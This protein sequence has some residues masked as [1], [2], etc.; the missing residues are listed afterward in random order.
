MTTDL[1][2]H[3]AT[4]ISD[5]AKRIA[6][7]PGSGTP[8]EC[9][10]LLRD[11]TERMRLKAAEQ[12]ELEAKYRAQNALAIE[13]EKEARR[14]A[15]A[16]YEVKRIAH[17]DAFM[18]K[19]YANCT[20]DSFDLHNADGSTSRGVASKIRKQQENVVSAA[21]E[22]AETVNERIATGQNLI[23]RGPTGTGKDHLAAAVAKYVIR[24]VKAPKDEC[25]LGEGRQLLLHCVGANF[26]GELKA[27]MNSRSARSEHEIVARYAN[28]VMLVLSDPSLPGGAELTEYQRGTLFQLVDTRYRMERP[29]ICTM[30]ATCEADMHKFLGSQIAERLLDGAVVLECQWPSVREPELIVAPQRSQSGT[31]MAG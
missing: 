5:H 3:I 8:E 14:Q 12:Q 22:Y 26:F 27:S 24:F 6:A 15:W 28:A 2:P 1:R 17:A 10:A 29:I 23:F 9:E 11:K 31:I 16:D 21:R 25:F 7:M 18:G 19:R 20:F 4:P 30:N 13:K